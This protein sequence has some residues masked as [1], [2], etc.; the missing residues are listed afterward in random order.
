MPKSLSLKSGYED[1]GCK[2][3]VVS[4]KTPPPSDPKADLRGQPN[5]DDCAPDAGAAPRPRKNQNS[6][7]TAREPQPAGRSRCRILCTHVLRSSCTQKFP[8][9]WTTCGLTRCPVTMPGSTGCTLRD[10]LLAWALACK[11]RDEACKCSLPSG[12]IRSAHALREWQLQI[13][14]S[15]SS[16]SSSSSGRRAMA[17]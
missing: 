5:L 10:Y 1:P 16:S 15:S 6:T 13:H 17:C 11:V 3:S 12:L 14:Q 2:S 7:I 4:G 8:P 9:V